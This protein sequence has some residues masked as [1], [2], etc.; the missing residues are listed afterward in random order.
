MLIHLHSE[1]LLVRK[2]T[3]DKFEALVLY[4]TIHEK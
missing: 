1:F 2:L 4:L 3:K